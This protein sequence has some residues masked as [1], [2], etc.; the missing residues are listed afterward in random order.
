M[1]RPALSLVLLAL[2]AAPAGAYTEPI[3]QSYTRTSP[4]GAFV[5]VVLHPPREGVRDTIAEKYPRSGLYRNGSAELVWAFTGG[6]VREAWPASDGAHLVTQTMKVIQPRVRECGNSP[7]EPPYN[8]P[9]LAVY[10]NGKK[11]RD[12]KLGELL[13]GE[14][15]WQG[16]APGWYPW[17]SSARVNDAAGAFEVEAV[18][19]SRTALSLATGRAVRAD[20]SPIGFCGNGAENPGTRGGSGPA[21][22]L[23][24]L[25]V[26]VAGTAAV[27]VVLFRSRVPPAE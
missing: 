17:L 12:V 24:L 5:F 27:A 25:G 1:R 23:T 3:W 18:D 4:D 7:P 16:K 15:F 20:D 21:L 22:G 6:Y 9:V 10:A 8:P 2:A 13:D 26:V 11:V 19:G 14:R